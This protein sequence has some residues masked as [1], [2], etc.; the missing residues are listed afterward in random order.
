MPT[1]QPAVDHALGQISVWGRRAH[2]PAA[3]RQCL[4]PAA[5]LAV[6][7]SERHWP[8]SADY[9]IV[10]SLTAQVEREAVSLSA[11]PVCLPA[12]ANWLIA[13]VSERCRKGETTWIVLRRKA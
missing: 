11:L 1:Y 4:P 8:T 5:P 3:L 6:H 13:Q 10:E 12:A 7:D 9:Y 2:V